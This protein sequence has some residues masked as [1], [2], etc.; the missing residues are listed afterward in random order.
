[1]TS[2]RIAAAAAALTLVAAAGCGNG[3]SSEGTL[4]PL[5]SIAEYPALPAIIGPD[6]TVEWSDYSGT[7]KASIDAMVAAN[8]CIGL[9]RQLTMAANDNALAINRTGHTNAKLMGYIH[10]RVDELSCATRRR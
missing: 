10:D 6:R 3:Q 1:M 7:A 5:R 9:E 8:D 4:P 2:V